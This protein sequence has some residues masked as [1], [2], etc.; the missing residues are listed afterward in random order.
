MHANRGDFHGTEPDKQPL[1]GSIPSAA[2]KA[3][4]SSGRERSP[5]K[6]DMVCTYC[7]FPACQHNLKGVS[8]CLRSHGSEEFA[9]GE[10]DR[11]SVGS[12]RW[13]L[14]QKACSLLTHG[15]SRRRKANLV[16]TCILE[17]YSEGNIGTRKE[18]HRKE[19]EDEPGRRLPPP[20]DRRA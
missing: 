14:M 12:V 1:S 20:R 17:N 13:H 4:I 19:E 11:V 6:T 8:S 7:L 9:R 18:A 3:S 10:E 2:G 16:L 15:R 5:G